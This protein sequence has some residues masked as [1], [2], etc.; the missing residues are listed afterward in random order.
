MAFN[1]N[2]RNGGGGYTPPEALAAKNYPARLVQLV[3]LG[4]QP[5]RPFQGNAKPPAEAM[6]VGYEL[7]HEFMTDE[8]GQP[9]GSKPRWVGEDFP[10]YSLDADR[11]KSTL[12]YHALDPEGTTGGDWLKLA[13]AAC[14]VTLTKEPRKGH[15]G[16]FVNY[17]SNVTGAMEAP[18]YTQPE[19]VNPIRI[20]DIDEPDMEVFAKLPKWMQD[21]VSSNL[22]F[23]GSAL[24]A[25]LAASGN[26]PEDKP[27]PTPAP[28]PAPAPSQPAA[29]KA[30]PKPPAPSAPNS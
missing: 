22:N 16:Q 15:E 6:Y 4:L 11:A 1:A 25:A 12:R 2:E 3:L 20:F 18:G 29:P 26:T 5:Q 10:F 27:K 17:I 9:D 28:T 19:L 23:E 24:Q 30:P 8:D 7:S 13:G 14:Q 21:K